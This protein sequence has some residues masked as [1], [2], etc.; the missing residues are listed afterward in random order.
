MFPQ[1][2]RV[3]LLLNS[4]FCCINQWNRLIFHLLLLAKRLGIGSHKFPG[5]SAVWACINIL[6]NDN[7][8]L[9]THTFK[10]RTN[11][12]ANSA[13]QTGLNI[14]LCNQPPNNRASVIWGMYCEKKKYVSFSF[15]FS[16]TNTNFSVPSP[17]VIV[18]KPQNKTLHPL[19]NTP[20]LWMQTCNQIHKKQKHF[21]YASD[22]WQGARFRT[23]DRSVLN[24]P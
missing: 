16:F 6:S 17:H 12:K 8:H 5:I 4:Q 9:H 24:F 13:V 7:M 18:Q 14:H 19:T 3:Q 23:N 11:H 10:N 15:T 21:L 20:L 2:G 22:C 1:H